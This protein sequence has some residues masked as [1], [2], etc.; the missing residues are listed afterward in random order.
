MLFTEI[1]YYYYSLY[2][3]KKRDLKGSPFNNTYPLK[4]AIWKIGIT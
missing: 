1:L 3:S 2:Y 4:L